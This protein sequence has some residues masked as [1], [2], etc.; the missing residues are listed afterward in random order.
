VIAH[1]LSTVMRADRIAVL[2]D[3]EIVEVGSHDEL[4]EAGGPYARL[5]RS[6]A[7]QAAA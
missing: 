2:H 7:E 1:R 5:Y 6:W 4:I 3:G